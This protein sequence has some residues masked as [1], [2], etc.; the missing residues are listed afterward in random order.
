MTRITGLVVPTCLCESLERPL[1]TPASYNTQS[2]W[3]PLLDHVRSMAG[4]YCPCINIM[5][6]PNFTHDQPF[7]SVVNLTIAT[8]THVDGAWITK[9]SRKGQR[10]L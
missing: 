9:P 10:S 2:G 4:Q 8:S 1:V 3:R 7:S 6:Q 5:Q